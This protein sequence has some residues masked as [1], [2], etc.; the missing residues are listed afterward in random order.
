MESNRGKS[1]VASNKSWGYFLS[2]ICS[3]RVVR[4]ACVRSKIISIHERKEGR[5]R[6]EEV[7]EEEVVEDMN[8]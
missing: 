1:D 4:R 7:E 6:K 3:V 8:S 2:S 5:G